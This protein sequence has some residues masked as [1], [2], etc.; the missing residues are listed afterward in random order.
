[1]LDEVLRDDPS[2]LSFE[3]R[4][5]VTTHGMSNAVKHLLWREGL[6]L[7]NRS[8]RDPD[9]RRN[10]LGSEIHSAVAQEVPDHSCERW[11]CAQEGGQLQRS[12]HD[13]LLP[14]IHAIQI[15]VVL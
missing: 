6:R 15:Q 12:E 4:L 11:N 8:I 5:S 7:S 3:L 2:V 14:E 9:D 1:M 13:P 10:D